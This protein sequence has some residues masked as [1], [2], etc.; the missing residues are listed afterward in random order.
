V[1]EGLLDIEFLKKELPEVH[2]TPQAG[3][4]TIQPKAAASLEE[5]WRKHLDRVKLS[6]SSIPEIVDTTEQYWEGSVRKV[7]VNAYERDQRARQA[8]IEHYGTDCL[9][10]GF[11]FEKKYG[12]LGRG[13]I[14]V[15]HVVDLSE[16][17]E[18][19]K[20]DPVKDLV[21]VCPNCHAMLHWESKPART[22]DRLRNIISNNSTDSD[23]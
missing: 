19:Y 20:V 3:G 2:W 14:H 1:E 4:I 18:E 13:Y 11:D 6:P 9:V 17:G 5:F 23:S 8:S 22:V 21:P 12:S 16:I 7:Q 10:C 15:H